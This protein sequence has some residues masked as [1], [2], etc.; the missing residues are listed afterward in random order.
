MT[1]KV[2]TLITELVNF[3][4][5]VRY[6]FPGLGH[7]FNTENDGLLPCNVTFFVLILP[8]FHPWTLCL[9]SLYA[10][11]PFRVYMARPIISFPQT[12]TVPPMYLEAIVKL[13]PLVFYSVNEFFLIHGIVYL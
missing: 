12:H 7:S 6:I 4:L 9:I 3:D 13:L 1:R 11:E 10:R 8:P 2:S 5:H